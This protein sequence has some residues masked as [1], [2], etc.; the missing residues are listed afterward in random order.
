[1]TRST[2]DFRFS[3]FFCYLVDEGAL[4]F[5][6]TFMGMDKRGVRCARGGGGGGQGRGLT[7]VAFC[8]V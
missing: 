5:P 4:H 8:L 2:Y 6:F 3:F 1:M 7:P